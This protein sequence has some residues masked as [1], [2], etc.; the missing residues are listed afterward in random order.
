MGFQ[1]AISPL[2]GF[3]GV[4]KTFSFLLAATGGEYEGASGDTPHP[5]R[6]LCPLHS[7]TLGRWAIPCSHLDGYKIVNPSHLCPC[8][9]ETSQSNDILR[10]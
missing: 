4:P 10:S 1:G 2:A 9:L 7:L 5:G 8:S 6:R 3:W